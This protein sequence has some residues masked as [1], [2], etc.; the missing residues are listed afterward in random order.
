MSAEARQYIRGSEPI[1]VPPEYRD[2]VINNLVMDLEPYLD[3]FPGA[4]VPGEI[5]SLARKANPEAIPDSG[6]TWKGT[7][8]RSEL[9]YRKYL[10]PGYFEAAGSCEE[11]RRLL[12][13]CTSAKIVEWRFGVEESGGRKWMSYSKIYFVKSFENTTTFL[14][15]W[16]LVGAALQNNLA[17]QR[18][19]A[20]KAQHLMFDFESR[21][22]RMLPITS[23]L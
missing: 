20:Q 16:D 14:A 11:E 6:A 15:A 19:R 7:E 3:K 10:V 17:V 4:M 9:E 22:A 21:K 5:S 1:E 12:I 8:V 2:A 23:Q 18:Q 13:L